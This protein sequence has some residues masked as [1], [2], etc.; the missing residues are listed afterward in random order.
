MFGGMAAPGTPVSPGRLASRENDRA[1]SD[2]RF[3]LRHHLEPARLAWA[4]RLAARWGVRPHDV[5]IATGWISAEDYTRA[6]AAYCGVGFVPKEQAAALSPRRG[7]SFKDCMKTGLLRTQDGRIVYAPG[8]VAPS[9]LR[10]ACSQ[11]PPG[12]LW[13]TAQPSLRRT[14]LRAFGRAIAVE[15]RDGL[16]TRAPDKAAATPS[17]YWQRLG[18]ALLLL[19][20][21]A[22]LWMAPE[23]LV[24]T[25]SLCLTLA[26]VPVIGLRVAALRRLAREPAPSPARRARIA[27]NQLPIYTLLAPLYREARM[28]LEAS[29][30]ETLAAIRALRLPGNFKIVTVPDF[31]PRPSA[32]W[33]PWRSALPASGSA[34]ASVSAADGSCPR[35][36]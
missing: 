10:A 9:V 23:T 20:L 22:G 1:P 16:R 5:L 13:L 18:P 7:A 34:M 15:A 36:R 33:P 11:L 35:S 2:Y 3:L 26:F 14:A 12:R 27:D 4:E 30:R 31:A 28:V 19:G 21:A 25:I 8:A 29:D 32:I 6:L 24:R 17:P